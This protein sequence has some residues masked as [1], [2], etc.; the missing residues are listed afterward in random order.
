MSGFTTL[1]L[2]AAAAA[3][4]PITPVQAK[5]VTSVRVA[6]HDLDLATARGQRILK[7]RIVRAA[8]SVCQSVN[9]R[10]DTEVR[11]RQRQCQDATVSAALASAAVKTRLAAR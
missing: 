1:I 2:L 10:F 5:E 6:T 8:N 4:A 7:L 11:I 9:P 3:T